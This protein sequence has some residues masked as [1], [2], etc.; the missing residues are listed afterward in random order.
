MQFLHDVWVNWF[1]GE[2]YGYGVYEFHEWRKEDV[3][4]LL[5]QVP[6]LKVSSELFDYIE[7]GM[8]EIPY[9]LLNDVYGKAYQRKNHK[10]IQLEYCFIISDGRGILAVDTMGYNIPIRKSR[11][12]PRQEQLV[13]DFIEDMEVLDYSFNKPEKYEFF[14][15]YSPTP[16]CFI[17]LT[18]REKEIKRLFFMSL[19]NIQQN[20]NLSELR[21]WYTEIN[22]VKYN[23]ILHMTFD[24]LWDKFINSIKHRWDK[25][26]ENVFEKIIKGQPQFELLYNNINEIN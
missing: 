24:E 13:F 16:D 6:L 10:R 5:D 14:N 12:I 26:L 9:Q 19:D 1:E 22:P 18:R 7:N 4:E 3:V 15:I 11:L 2:E 21:Y 17:G 20:K 23:D 25:D 8:N